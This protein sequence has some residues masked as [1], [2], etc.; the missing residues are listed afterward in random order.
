MTTGQLAPVLRY[1]RRVGGAAAG[2][3]DRALLERF[4]R[5][6][7]AEAFAALVRR[8]GPMVL[9]V[10]RRLL[11]NGHDADDAFQAVFLL[12]LRKAGSLRRPDHLGPWLHGVARRVALKARC[13]GLRRRGR[14]EPLADP[15]APPAADDLVWRDLRPV[16]DDAVRSLPAKYR[17]PF[18]LCYLQG[19]TYAEAARHLDCPP[20][21]VATR[22]SRAREQLRA[23]LVRRGVTLSAGALA[24]TLA[25]AAEAAV[26]PA[27]FGSVLHAAGPSAVVPSHIT[28]LTEGVCQAMLVEKLRFV[29][30]ALVAA[31]AVGAL[32]MGYRSGAAEP[33]GFPPVIPPAASAPPTGR[34]EKEGGSAVVETKNFTVTAP[35]RGLATL[36]AEAAERHRKEK[37]LLWLGQE[38]PAWPE[39][40]PIQ[41]KITMNGTSGATTFEFAEEP[42]ADRFFAGGTSSTRGF[43]FQR[44]KVKSRSMQLEGSLER[45]LLS[46]LP[47]EVTHTV[48]ADHFGK[49]V[50][51]WADEGGAVL[52]EDDEEQQRHEKLARTLV[53]TPGRAIPLRRLFA[54]RDFPEDVMAL[55]AQGYSVTRFLVARKDRKTFLVFVKQGM[56]DGWDKAVKEH[57]DFRD[58]EA[59]EDTW[60][61]ELRKAAPRPVT[62][63][64]LTAR[65]GEKR[66]AVSG[67]PP[68]TGDAV[69]DKEGR[70]C[71]NEVSAAAVYVPVQQPVKGTGAGTGTVPTYSLQSVTR[72]L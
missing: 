28:A 5:H 63:P 51:R 15:P 4:T 66:P 39:P 53:E 40:C 23:R 1:I 60:L 49:P 65:V 71:L 72:L 10:C 35:T 25:G 70:L 54:M 56:S 16:L 52:S 58:V 22:L 62:L 36:F 19:M 37:A 21:T 14:E 67:V 18:V 44:G 43:A 50:A 8:H 11:H 38:L 33:G 3:G 47:H 7:D 48:F 31:A 68:T 42:T 9:G 29:V 6:G 2:D 59:L 61:A 27:L 55:Y 32:V 64:P 30:M 24:A 69:I 13:L 41:V 34:A 17:T 46:A 45:L 20:G 26:T 12:L 57:Y